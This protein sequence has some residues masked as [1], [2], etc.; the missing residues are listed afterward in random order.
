[1]EFCESDKEI[2]RRAMEMIESDQ[3]DA[4]IL[5]YWKNYDIEEIAQEMGLSWGDAN[6]LIDSAQREVK[7]ILLEDFGFKGG[8]KC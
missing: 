5:R 8:K 1:M 2:L 4:L 7:R 3:A 6:K